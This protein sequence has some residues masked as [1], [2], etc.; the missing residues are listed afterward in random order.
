MPVLL[1][2]TT[3][4]PSSHP[5]SALSSAALQ[6]TENLLK[7]P[8]FRFLHDIVSEVTRTTGFA[9]GLYA[10]DELVSGSIKD[11]DAKVG[12]CRLKPAETRV[13]SALVS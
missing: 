9:E 3:A 4:L 13:E 11:K 6:L 8:P 2:L 10:D 1:E 7:K 12:R 5:R